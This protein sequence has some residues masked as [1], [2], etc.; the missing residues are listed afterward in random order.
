[1]AAAP[2]PNPL[3]LP[4]PQ[5]LQEGAQRGTR[6]QIERLLLRLKRSLSVVL[7]FGKPGTRAFNWTSLF[8]NPGVTTADVY[9]NMRSER[10]AD[11]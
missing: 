9:I 5:D 3:V 7:I 1:M 8:N 4:V 6:L 11:G 2:Q 10:V